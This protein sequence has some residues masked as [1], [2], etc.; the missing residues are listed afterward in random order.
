MQWFYDWLIPACWLVW[1]VWWQ[2]A[3]GSTKTTQRIE[4][5]ASRVFRTVLFLGGVAL[6]FWTSAPLPWLYRHL[7]TPSL[8]TFWL[9]TAI[10]LAGLLFAVW[11]RLILGA[12]WSR[13]VTIKQDHELITRGPYKLIRHPIYTG[14][15]IGFLGTALAITELRALV[16]FVLIFLSLWY[17]LRLEE[18]WMS[19]QFGQTYADYARH[20]AALIPWLI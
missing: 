10:T 15:L 11:A 2:I 1:L 18:K 5:I 14:M 3:A 8:W 12:N 17:K 9:G 19:A 7:V 4:S 6:L 16:A 20:T 13:S